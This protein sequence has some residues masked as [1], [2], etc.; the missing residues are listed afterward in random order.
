M[1]KSEHC[2]LV[3]ACYCDTYIDSAW[4][5]CYDEFV[6]EKSSKNEIDAFIFHV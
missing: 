2:S 4:F 3:A 6:S 1:Q 5:L